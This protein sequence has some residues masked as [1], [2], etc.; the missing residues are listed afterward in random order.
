[1]ERNEGDL[2][3]IEGGVD[4]MKGMNPQQGR[5]QDHMGWAKKC[6]SFGTIKTYVWNSAKFRSKILDFF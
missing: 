3:L 4:A 1:M 2:H 5:G 6:V